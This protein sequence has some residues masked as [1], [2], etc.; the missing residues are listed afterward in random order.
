M[1]PMKKPSLRTSLVFVLLILALVAGS[2]IALQR[3]NDFQTEGELVLTGLAAPVE[4][5]RD[6]N[7]MAY[8]HAQSLE[9][10]LFAQGFLTAQ[11]RFFNMHL[12]RLMIQGRLTELAGDAA[13]DLDVQN[14]TLGFYRSARGHLALLDERTLALFQR[15]VDGVNAFLECCP[16]DLH[17][18]FRLAGVEAEPWKIEDSM[19]LLYL[20]AWNSSAN[21]KHE[22]VYAQLAAEVGELRARTLDPLNINPDEADTEEADTE[23]AGPDETDLPETQDPELGADPE[24]AGDQITRA[25]WST[26]PMLRS[27]MDPGALQVGS[28]NWVAGPEI[29]AG[30]KALLAGDPHL[31]PRMLPGVWH[32]IGLIWPGNRA[33]GATV[34]GLPG[35][36]LGRTGHIALSMTNAYGDAQDLYLETVDPENP[37]RYLEGDQS[38]AFEK[39]TETLRI[40]DD[41]SESGFREEMIEIR[42]TRRGPVVSGRLPG[43][44]EERLVT[45]RWA[46]ADPA[47]WTPQIGFFQLLEAR[48][49]HG[50]NRSIENLPMIGLNFVFA[51]TSGAIG[52]RVSGRLPTRLPGAGQRPWTVRDATDPWTGWIPLDEMPQDLSDSKSWLGTANHLTVK[53][54]YAHYYTNRAAA[55]YRYV[56]L[57]EL[58][59]ERIETGEPVT[60]NDFWQWQRDVTNP[61]ARELAP[62]FAQALQQDPQ[63]RNLGRVLEGWDHQDSVDAAGPLVFQELIRQTA[64]ATFSDQL[65]PAVTSALLDNLYYWQERFQHMLADVDPVAASWLD[66]VATDAVESRDEIIVRAGLAALRRLT[67]E[68]G[69]DPATWRWG[70]PHYLKLYHPLRRTGL[71]SDWL[72]SGRLPMGG[73]A[74]TLYRGWYNFHEPYAATFTASLRMVVD[75]A[76]PDKIRAV[77]PGGAVGRAFHPHQQDQTAAFMAGTPLW[78]WFSDQAIEAGAQSRLHLQPAS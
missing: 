66:D 62:I 63:T 22:L 32:P 20:M 38:L 51:D 69:P 61:M 73:S 8:A 78:W 14:R 44:G 18:E 70:K 12:V 24:T 26:D 64:L 49:I 58:F 46:A 3:S 48:D 9:D 2:W 57:K 54:D 19:A 28:N 23:E 21:L 45:L 65:G 11:D 1:H 13:R 35:I 36:G 55:S 31:D 7:G 52:W 76:D 67:P 17:L 16:S 25:V 74:E 68:E 72:G 75:F 30:G 27:L 71:G 41:Q 43:L 5:R 47:T 15:Y 40:R 33:V 77:L 29:T 56:R 37:D 4:V 6:E 60:E 10:A 39:L 59:A 42:S 50:V 34:A 53:K